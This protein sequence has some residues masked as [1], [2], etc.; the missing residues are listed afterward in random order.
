MKRTRTSLLA[1]WFLAASVFCAQAQSPVLPGPGLPTGGVVG[2]PTLA[3]IACAAGSGAGSVE[4]LAGANIGTAAGFTTRRI[5]VSAAGNGGVG[6]TALVSATIGGI[7]ATINGQANAGTQQ[8]AAIFSADV[9]TGTTATIVATYNN[10]ISAAIVLCTYSVDDAKLISTTPSV[11]TA[12]AAG[13]VTTLTTSS[14]TQTTGGF[15]VGAAG[16][17]GG[18]S[19]QSIT[20]Y[21]ADFT[22]GQSIQAHFAPVVATG[23]TTAT[24]NWTTAQ[25]LDVLVVA[26][27]R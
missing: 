4:T 8:I 15:I 2:P 13:S 27:W 14:F 12:V 3:A 20:G 21:S 25:S 26:A 17:G 9:P 5:I 1:T 11:G 7:A 16:Y 6:P 23:S 19:S 24:T 10:T 22:G 18:V